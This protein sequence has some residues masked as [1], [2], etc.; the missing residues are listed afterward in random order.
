M[1]IKKRRPG[2]GRKPLAVPRNK[3]LPR[4]S[5]PAHARLL[6]VARANGLTIAEQIERLI[7]ENGLKP[8]SL[9]VFGNGEGYRLPPGVSTNVEAM[10][11][12]DTQTPKHNGTL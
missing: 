1:S 7:P 6:E 8:S 10:A 11:S 4:I 5:T 2:G 9:I 12:A 3:N